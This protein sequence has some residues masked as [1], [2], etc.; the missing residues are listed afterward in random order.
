MDDSFERI[1]FSGLTTYRGGGGETRGFAQDSAT[2]PIAIVRRRLSRGKTWGFV[3]SHLSLSLYE[4]DD[5]S[6]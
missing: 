5:V 1:V 2:E 4:R 3:L 6:W